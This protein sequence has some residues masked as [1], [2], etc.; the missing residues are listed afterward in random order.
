MDDESI[1]YLNDLL[2]L[3]KINSNIKITIEG[4]TDNRGDFKSNIKLSKDRSETIRDFLV[5]NGIKKSQIKVKGLG[6][7]KPRYSNESENSRRL[8]RRVELFIN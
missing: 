2:H 7:S 6:P 4:H 1:P 3:F 8:N 5:M